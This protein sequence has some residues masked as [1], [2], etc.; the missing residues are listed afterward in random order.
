MVRA[1]GAPRRRHLPLPLPAG[2]PLRFRSRRALS[3]LSDRRRGA[4]GRDRHRDA[5]HPAARRHEA[6]RIPR[7]VGLGHCPGG[8]DPGLRRL[9]LP[10]PDRPDPG[11]RR[12]LGPDPHG[13][14]VRR[15]EPGHHL[16]R[17]RR[18]N[19]PLGHRSRAGTVLRQHGLVLLRS[20]QRR[21]RPLVSP[22]APREPDLAAARSGPEPREPRAR[23]RPAHAVRRR[24]DEQ[25]GAVEP[26]RRR[27]RGGGR[28]D[29]HRRPR[30]TDRLLQH[31][32]RRAVGP[33]PRPGHWPEHPPVAPEPDRS[34]ER[35]PP[36]PAD[37]R[38]LVRRDPRHRDQR[39]AGPA[40]AHRVPGAQPRGPARSR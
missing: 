14:G 23:D 36:G 33:G 9:P 4:P 12:G 2:F 25:R 6:A 40:L 39:Q 21:P 24:A 17:L 30:G 20:R 7:R 28:G 35:H 37:H 32:R 38:T 13:R 15:P 27:R 16:R 29:L 19:P 5:P 31:G 26:L 22:E 18:A 34:R 10:L 8:D 11:R 3:R 1:H